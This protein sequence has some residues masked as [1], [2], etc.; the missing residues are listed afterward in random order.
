MLFCRPPLAG[1]LPTPVPTFP[2]PTSHSSPHLHEG[3]CQGLRAPVAHVCISPK[4]LRH[5]CISP[6][7]CNCLCKLGELICFLQCMHA[8]THAAILPPAATLQPRP[9]AP[10]WLTCSLTTG[11][12]VSAAALQ[13]RPLAPEWLTCSLTIRVCGFSCRTPAAPPRT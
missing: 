10:E 4:H 6:S 12:A 5:M 2:L 11:V 13:P 9:L 1:P 7:T 3:L 8:D